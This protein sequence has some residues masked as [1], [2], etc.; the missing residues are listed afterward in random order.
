MGIVRTVQFV[1]TLVVAGPMALAGLFH[2]FDGQYPQAAA[3]LAVALVVVLLSEYLYVRVTDG[4]VGRLRR[5][6]PRRTRDD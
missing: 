1:A 3:F 6:N 4:T 2:A 5:L